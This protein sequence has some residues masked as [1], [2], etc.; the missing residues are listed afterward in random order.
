[1]D[2]L[3]GDQNGIPASS[4]PA[5]RRAVV[6]SS[7]RTQRAAFLWFVAT[8]AAVLPSGDNERPVD[9]VPNVK[10]EPSGGLI[11]RLNARSSAGACRKRDAAQVLR[12][13]SSRATVAT[14][15]QR[16]RSLERGGERFAQAG[17]G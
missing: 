7:G 6:P 3:S 2:L 9:R 1:M 15:H 12:A 14:I 4:V 17:G 16:C 13:I 10:S 5:S 11:W 8:K